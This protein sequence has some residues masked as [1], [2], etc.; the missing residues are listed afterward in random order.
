M[1]GSSG[2]LF[3]NLTLLCQPLPNRSSRVIASFSPSPSKSSH[4]FDSE[5]TA[6]LNL[7]LCGLN[8]KSFLSIEIL[9]Q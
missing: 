1:A 3:E 8:T 9:K 6:S 7:C 2:V 4:F 5:A